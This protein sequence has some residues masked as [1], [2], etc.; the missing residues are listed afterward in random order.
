LSCNEH[1]HKE[2]YWDY[3]AKDCN[4]GPG[5]LD[6]M[7]YRYISRLAPQKAKFCRRGQ[8]EIQ[9]HVQGRQID[10]ENANY[11]GWGGR[12]KSDGAIGG[13]K[14]AGAWEYQVLSSQAHGPRSQNEFLCICVCGAYLTDTSVSVSA[15][16]LGLGYMGKVKAKNRKAK[17]GLCANRT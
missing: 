13:M 8:C 9:I 16:T 14:G 6:H 1:S 10:L 2:T 11:A 3:L 7:R 12:Y 17:L 5:S 4:I 15:Q